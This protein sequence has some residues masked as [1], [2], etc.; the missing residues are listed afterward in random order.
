MKPQQLAIINP[1]KSD[2][3][4]RKIDRWGSIPIINLPV[5]WWIEEFTLDHQIASSDPVAIY[6]DEQ[7][8][9]LLPE[10]EGCLETRNNSSK[11]T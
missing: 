2:R 1:Q 8:E 4:A 3:A 10:L 6:S 5:L 7:V 9:Q 11:H